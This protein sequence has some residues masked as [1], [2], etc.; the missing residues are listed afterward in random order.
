MLREATN[1]RCCKARCKNGAS[2]LTCPI[3]LWQCVKKST[4]EH[5]PFCFPTVARKRH[6]THVQPS[7]VMLLRLACSICMVSNEDFCDK[8]SD[9][10]IY[11]AWK[12][13]EVP[14]ISTKGHQTRQ[15]LFRYPR[16]TKP[17][18][19]TVNLGKKHSLQRPSTWEINF[20]F[21]PSKVRATNSQWVERN[22]NLGDVGIICWKVAGA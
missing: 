21:S 22:P 4:F 14:E 17:E 18:G 7:T 11:Q 1:V 16:Y 5:I 15:D 8:S 13:A 10:I 20:C 9:I 19:S 6:P 12:D 2:G 3:L